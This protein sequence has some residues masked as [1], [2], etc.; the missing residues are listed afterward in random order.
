MTKTQEHGLKQ[1]GNVEKNLF[2]IHFLQVDNNAYSH[3][4]ICH[5]LV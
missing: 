3:E 2:K 1:V 5:F 4:K